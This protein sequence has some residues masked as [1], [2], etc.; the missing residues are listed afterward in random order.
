MHVNCEIKHRPVRLLHY[1]LM[2]FAPS[3]CFERVSYI[4]VSTDLVS[5]FFAP[6]LSVVLATIGVLH[7]FLCRKGLNFSSSLAFRSEMTL[8]EI[9]PDTLVVNV[10]PAVFVALG[11]AI[12]SY[13]FR[14]CRIS[15]VYVLLSS[16]AEKVVA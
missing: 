4:L 7:G 13:S 6:R 9:I 10:F 15:I 16:L 8:F 5:S 14:R 12:F 2:L 1:V 11:P 3:I